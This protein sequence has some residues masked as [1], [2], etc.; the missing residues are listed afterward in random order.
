M[1]EKSLSDA[2]ADVRGAKVFGT[3]SINYQHRDNM[4]TF[5]VSQSCEPCRTAFRQWN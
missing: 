1:T 2:G 4:R 5:W 3:D